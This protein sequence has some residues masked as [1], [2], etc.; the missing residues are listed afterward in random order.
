MAQL[1]LLDHRRYNTFQLNTARWH[2][3]SSLEGERKCKMSSD[4]EKGVLKYWKEQVSAGFVS[5]NK[6]WCPYLHVIIRHKMVWKWNFWRRPQAVEIQVKRKKVGVKTDFKMRHGK[7]V[8]AGPIHLFRKTIILLTIPV[9]V[10]SQKMKRCQYVGI[11]LR[12]FIWF[13]VCFPCNLQY[14][15][16]SNVVG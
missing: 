10:R 14:Q 13:D 6:G 12:T 5:C 16:L 8:T 2:N 3:A 4:S 9:K 11:L 1:S 7:S 15:N